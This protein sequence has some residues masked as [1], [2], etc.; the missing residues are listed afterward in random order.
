M[1]EEFAF[2]LPIVAGKLED[3]KAYCNEMDSGD[4]AKEWDES[5]RRMGALEVKVFIQPIGATGN[6]AVLIAY[7]KVEDTARVV[8][9]LAESQE[10]FDV[11]FREGVLEYHN[12][13]LA[14][15]PLRGPP[16]EVIDWQAE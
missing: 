11:W 2:A 16:T 4:R 1:A 9:E 7:W 14:R 5:R 15:G 12:V 8:R 6:R 3:V 10:P 13:D